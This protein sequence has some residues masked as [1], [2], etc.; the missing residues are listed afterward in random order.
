MIFYSKW[1]Y[2]TILFSEHDEESVAAVEN[3]EKFLESSN[4]CVANS[5]S[6]DN[7]LIKTTKKSASGTIAANVAVVFATA[8][9]FATFLRTVQSSSTSRTLYILTELSHD[10][11]L[12]MPVKSES[13][14]RIMYGSLSVQPVNK[15][16]QDFIEFL[17]AIRPDNFPER[18]FIDVFEEYHKCRYERNEIPPGKKYDRVCTSA[19]RFDVA[20]F[21]RMTKVGYL[22]SAL[23]SMLFGID[24]AYRR[25]C[26]AQQGVCADFFKNLHSELAN[27]AG[28]TQK[29]TSFEILNYQRL[30]SES[31][32]VSIGN[33]TTSGGLH[34]AKPIISYDVNDNVASSLP[35]SSCNPPLCRCRLEKDFFEIPVESDRHGGDD[36]VF[37]D[38]AMMQSGP[39][40]VASSSGVVSLALH[41]WKQRTWSYIFLALTSVLLLSALAVLGIVAVKMC[42]RVIKGNQSLGISLLLGIIMMYGCAYFFIF[43]PSPALCRLRYFFHSFSYSIC[44]GVMI[45]KAT[46]LRNSETIGYDGYISYW[47]YWLLLC[48][49]VGVQIALNLQWVLLHDPVSY[50]VIRNSG[51]EIVV[52]QCNW[53]VNEF[54]VSHIY[55]FI[56]LFLVWLHFFA[57][58]LQLFEESSGSIVVFEALSDS[59]ELWEGFVKQNT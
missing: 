14:Y 38:E 37:L 31:K 56:L 18:W 8:R 43:D 4:L 40:L 32:Y 12:H 3:F 13:F 25:Y 5:V 39:K 46:Q 19:D 24:G 20:E 58:F 47:N 26:P 36:E 6:V 49:I 34:L 50:N 28:K 27:L 29:E 21:G 51:D 42:S 54:L 44:F 33:F 2:I 10:W 17:T 59:S 22:M 55:V 23:E 9:D 7:R 52:Q 53:T 57:Y 15:V 41:S 16:T 11:K 1:N 35:D 30:G 48:F 45:A